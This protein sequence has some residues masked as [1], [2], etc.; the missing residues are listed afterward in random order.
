MV[1]LTEKSI[2]GLAIFT[3]ELKTSAHIVA[4]LN[5]NPSHPNFVPSGLYNSQES[6]C[7]ALANHVLLRIMIL[8]VENLLR[9]RSFAYTKHCSQWQYLSEMCSN[10]FRERGKEMRAQ[11]KFSERG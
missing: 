7:I 6:P 2:L 1:G 9:F 8:L 4:G 10:P 5:G 11:L 3:L